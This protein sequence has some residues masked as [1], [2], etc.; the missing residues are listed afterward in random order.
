MDED[1][2]VVE[3]EEEGEEEHD[4]AVEHERLL[5]KPFLFFFFLACL[6]SSDFIF[7]LR[8]LL[9]F[10]CFFVSLHVIQNFVFPYNGHLFH[11]LRRTWVGQPFG[12]RLDEIADTEM[13]EKKTPVKCKIIKIM[14]IY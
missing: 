9:I 14:Y 7:L 4:E 5:T 3:E 12:V 2:V 8:F 6:A 11:V 10:F 13:V 1:V